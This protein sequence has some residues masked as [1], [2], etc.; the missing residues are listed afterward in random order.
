MHAIWGLGQM[1]FSKFIV[2][3]DADVNVHSTSE[4]L[5]R[6]G[7]NVDPK[8]DIVVVDGPV[9]AL[10]HAA[11]SLCAGSKMGIDAT[12]KI[13]GEGLLRPWPEI[14]R[15]DEKVKAMVEANWKNYGID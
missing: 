14:L 12:A 2:V 7:S 5:F 10:D 4:V 8:R 15:M 9:D 13:D 1:M 3:V 11:P 6:M